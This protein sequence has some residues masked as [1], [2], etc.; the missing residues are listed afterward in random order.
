MP[1]SLRTAEDLHRLP[2]SDP[3]MTEWGV[4]L[5]DGRTGRV[6]VPRPIYDAV[7]ATDKDAYVLEALA[8]HL[9]QLRIPDEA[10][11]LGDHLVRRL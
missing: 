2:S 6:R 1:C 9:N 11:L 4:D 10:L 7:E 3:A 8:D 5:D